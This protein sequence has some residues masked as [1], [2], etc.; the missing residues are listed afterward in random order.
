MNCK[1]IDNHISNNPP[2]LDNFIQFI[3][4]NKDYESFYEEFLRI[5]YGITPYCKL[6]EDKDILLYLYFMNGCIYAISILKT[7]NQILAYTTAKIFFS[8][9]DIDIDPKLFET[10]TYDSIEKSYYDLSLVKKDIYET[11][12]FN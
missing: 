4:S 12:I 6:S 8:Q 7:T 9:C 2:Y 3:P 10:P 5:I 11:F 1:N